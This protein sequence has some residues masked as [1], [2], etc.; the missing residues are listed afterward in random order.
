MEFGIDKCAVLVMKK[1]EIVMVNEMKDNVKK[2]YYKRAR[3]V[4]ETKLRCGNVWKA[5]NT[6]AV[7]VVI[8]CIIPRVVK[9]STR[10][11]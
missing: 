11:D 9:T 7:S 8:F 1:G 6:W 3:K 2:E 10:G 4:F 5:L